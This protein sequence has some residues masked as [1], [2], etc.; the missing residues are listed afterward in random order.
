MNVVLRDYDAWLVAA[1][2]SVNTREAYLRDIKAFLNHVGNA[3]VDA[4]A[5]EGYLTYLISCGRTGSTVKR[6]TAALCSY[7]EY[8]LFGGYVAVN[9]VRTCTIPEVSDSNFTITPPAAV[10]IERLISHVCR[11]G[12]VRD[13]ALLSLIC[14][15]GATVSEL[16]ALTIR[17]VDLENRTI[18]YGHRRVR[19]S[20]AVVVLLKV[21]LEEL[22]YGDVNAP[23]FKGRSD[24]G[25]TRQG[26]WLV[27]KKWVES[28]GVCG[29]LSPRLLRSSYV[30]NPVFGCVAN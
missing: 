13:A 2:K 29:T 14:F 16:S 8:L 1:R 3:P 15:T 26:V 28:A 6:V 5:V 11:Y 27:C 21:L 17:D 30:E 4:Q 19:L 18:T 23:V 9:P 12:T 25:L 10:D 22:D 7:Y 24:G 20:E